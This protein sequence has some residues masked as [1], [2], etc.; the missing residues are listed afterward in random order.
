MPI[1]HLNIQTREDV[2]GKIRISFSFD[3]AYV[4]RSDYGLKSTYNGKTKCVTHINNAY[5]TVHVLVT[6]K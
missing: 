1:K 5:C 3:I 4:N 6:S 2:M